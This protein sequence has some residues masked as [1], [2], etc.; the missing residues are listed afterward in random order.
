MQQEEANRKFEAY[1]KQHERE[2]EKERR[3]R[4]EEKKALQ[5]S[6]QQSNMK[7]DTLKKELEQRFLDADKERE[8]FLNEPI[9]QKINDLV[10]DLYITTKDNY[11]DYSKIG[12]DETS[13]AQLGAAVSKHFGNFKP[14]LLSRYPAIKSEELLQCYLYLLGL[15]DKQIAIL[16]QCNY[17]TVFRQ[18][19]KLQNNLRADAP[20]PDFVRKLAFS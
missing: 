17:S 7:V 13:I 3:N 10:R 8:A 2:L 1:S 4:K 14:K 12:L 20:L 11:S 18:S 19:K 6:L 16:R 9:C 5:K 15:K